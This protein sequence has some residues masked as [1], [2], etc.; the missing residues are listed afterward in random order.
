MTCQTIIDRA[1]DLADV[2]GSSFFSSTEQY[3]SLN[4]SY[5]D[6][7]EQILNSNDDYFSKENSFLYSSLTPITLEPTGFL[8]TLPVDFY[9]LRVI[10]FEHSGAF[11]SLKK[12]SIHEE[13]RT[14]KLPSY[15]FL[16]TKLKL[17]LPVGSAFT[18]F[19]LNY[20]PAPTVYATGIED[21]AIPPQLEPAIL[22]Y[23]IAIDIKRKQQSDYAMLQARR[24]EM[25]N[26]FMGAISKRDDSNYE[27]VNNA[28]TI[29]NGWIR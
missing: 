24:D 4:E 22:A 15:R 18:N 25:F 13:D 10:Q 7:Y 17:I 3:A 1:K 16:G 11:T 21:I 28:Y 5:R 9:R 29:N 6:L 27:S 12:Y 23:Q 2:A 26:R 14:G 19:R 20:Y 8:L